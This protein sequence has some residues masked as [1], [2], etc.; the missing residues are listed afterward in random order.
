MVGGQIIEEQGK[1]L[2]RFYRLPDEILAFGSVKGSKR[3][4]DF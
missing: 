3:S 1:P 2:S 4:A